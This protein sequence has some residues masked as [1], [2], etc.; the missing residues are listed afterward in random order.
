MLC[1][2]NTQLERDLMTMTILVNPFHTSIIMKYKK[3]YSSISSFN[4][5]SILYLVYLRIYILK[6]T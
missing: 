5:N 4:I 6:Y 1:Y 2:T 3:S